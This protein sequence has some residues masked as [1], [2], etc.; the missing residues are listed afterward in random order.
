MPRQSDPYKFQADP[1]QIVRCGGRAYMCMV[2][3]MRIGCEQCSLEGTRHCGY[4]ACDAD[5]RDDNL[6]VI[7]K[8]FNSEAL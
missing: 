5:D 8:L 7:F 2:D 3:R 6:D 4:F 1:G